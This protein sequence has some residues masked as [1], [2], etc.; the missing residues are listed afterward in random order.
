[1]RYAG[2]GIRVSTTGHVVRCSAITTAIVSTARPVA[3][4]TDVR[5]QTKL[6]QCADFDKKID[7]HYFLDFLLTDPTSSKTLA[8]V[9]TC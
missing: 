4:A 3:T 9:W 5:T 7:L 6:C 8:K 1:M 2:R